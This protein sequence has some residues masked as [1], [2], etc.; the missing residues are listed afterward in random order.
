MKKIKVA[1]LISGRGSNLKALIEACK[2]PNF[3]AQ[4]SLVISNKEDAF[5][6]EIAKENGIKTAF[7][8]NKLFAKRE[9]FDAKLDEA[10]TAHNCQIICL[11][12]FMRVL[13]AY[14]VSKWENKIINIHPS[15]LPAFKGAKAQEDA[16][17]Y[18]VKYSGCSV[19]YVCKEVDAGAIIE[20]AV[21][22]VLKGD[23]K[24]I[25][26]ARILEKEHIIYPKA[27]KKVCKEL[28]KTSN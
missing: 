4:I 1:V 10:I 5:G 11:A 15:L 25:L 27:L 6:L 16:L 21:V 20:Q 3:P 22:K 12:G 13:S 8:D 17:N 7:I 28:T 19:H 26:A 23:N 24:E 18:G 2:N 9:E 14:F